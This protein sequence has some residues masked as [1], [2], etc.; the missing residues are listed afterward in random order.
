MAKHGGQR[1]DNQ[2]TTVI[3]RALLLT[4]LMTE[5]FTLQA[6]DAIHRGAAL[7]LSTPRAV[8]IDICRFESV[9]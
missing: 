9:L 2:T 3:K 6:L 4:S 8:L 5:V 7:G 1:L